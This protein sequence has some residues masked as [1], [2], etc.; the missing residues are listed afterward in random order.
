MNLIK[1]IA[2]P[3]GAHENRNSL[4]ET[5]V[6][7]GWALIPKDITI[8]ESFPFV[9]IEVQEID[10]VQTV[11]EMSG[12]EIIVNE[13]EVKAKLADAVQLKITESKTVLSEYLASHPL[14][15]TDGKC[16]NVTSEKQAMLTNT[17]FRY[18][19]AQSTGQDFTLTWNSTGD[20]GVEW[21]YEDLVSL[22]FA[23]SNYVK[24]FVAR[25]QEIEIAIKACTTIEELELIDVQ[26]DD[27]NKEVAE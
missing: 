6:P 5:T 7:E 24:P 19:L 22:A 16:Y 17:L 21:K 13:E 10:G 9:D 20:E 12:H 26:Y 3:T 8:P 23:I 4:W 18:Q 2:F 14:Q 27:I 1:I 25:Q 11:I 15:W